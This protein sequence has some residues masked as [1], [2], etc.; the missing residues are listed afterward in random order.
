[1]IHKHTLFAMKTASVIHWK[2]IQCLVGTDLQCHQVW[3]QH[4]TVSSINSYWRVPS[5][6]IVCKVDGV[7]STFHKCMGL[8]W[9]ICSQSIIHTQWHSLYSHTCIQRIRFTSIFSCSLLTLTIFS[10]PNSPTFKIFYKCIFRKNYFYL[11]VRVCL[12]KCVMS[13]WVLQN[14]ALEPLKLELVVRHLT[15]ASNKASVL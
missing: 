9:A 7:M 14:R 10:L 15:G 2:I 12:C 6:S 3:T 5:F 4:L 8:S 13:V 1:M 11:C